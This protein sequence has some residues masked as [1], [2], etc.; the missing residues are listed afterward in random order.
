MNHGTHIPIIV[1]VFS[2]IDGEAIEF[3]FDGS[4]GQLAKLPAISLQRSP[5][6]VLICDGL[7]ENAMQRT[8]RVNYSNSRS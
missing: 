7:S 6:N 5:H 1:T 2:A 3:E 4:D 8:S